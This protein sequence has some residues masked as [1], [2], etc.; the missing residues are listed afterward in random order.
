MTWDPD[1]RFTPVDRVRARRVADETILLH[2]DQGSYYALN[3]VG[4]ELWSGLEEGR[5]L[6]EILARLLDRYEV[7]EE[8][9]REDLERVVGEL[10]ERDLVG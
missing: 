5:T 3:E 10:L 7:D 4:A 2:L 9:L 1:A 6:G 8:T